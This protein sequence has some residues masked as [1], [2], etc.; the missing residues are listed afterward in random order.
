MMIDQRSD[1][2][3]WQLDVLRLASARMTAAFVYSH[4]ES[5]LQNAKYVVHPRLA[6]AIAWYK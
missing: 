2:L 5:F 3:G 6:P 4:V 1:Q